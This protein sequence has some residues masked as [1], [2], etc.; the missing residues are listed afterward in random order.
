MGTG[1]VKELMQKE[2]EG[3]TMQCSYV[4]LN[5]YLGNAGCDAACNVPECNFD[6]GMCMS[7]ENI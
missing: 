6:D 5:F 1:R 4:C 2:G 7:N 3:C